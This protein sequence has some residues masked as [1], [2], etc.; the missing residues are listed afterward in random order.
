[1]LSDEEL[2]TIYDKVTAECGCTIKGFRAIA[3]EGLR[4]AAE[5]PVS[6]ESLH[7]IANEY[8]TINKQPPVAWQDWYAQRAL[9]EQV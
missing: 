5:E 1:M 8:D 3:A 7:S 9:E 6:T 2:R 4:K